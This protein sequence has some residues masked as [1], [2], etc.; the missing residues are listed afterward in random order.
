M[1]EKVIC[2]QIQ[3]AIYTKLLLR[4]KLLISSKW[5]EMKYVLVYASQDAEGQIL[6]HNSEDE[7]A[8]VLREAWCELH[9]PSPA[10]EESY[11]PDRKFEGRDRLKELRMAISPPTYKS[12]YSNIASAAFP[13]VWRIFSYFPFHRKPRR[14][15]ALKENVSTV[16]SGED[17]NHFCF[18]MLP[19]DSD[20]QTTLTNES[21]IGGL[22]RSSKSILLHSTE[23]SSAL[24]IVRK[25]NESSPFSLWAS[26]RS[27]Y[28]W[29]WETSLASGN[30]DI[31]R[32]DIILTA[33]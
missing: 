27:G 10:F 3:M 32:G 21:I 16:V 4:A 19:I 22:V 2:A 23:R 13:G 8:Q 12:S 5:K 11:V 31:M 33:F 24:Q 29:V 26:R 17:R 9:V 20:D 28:C 18:F 14:F 6:T 7:V 25:A 15:S 30:V 1:A